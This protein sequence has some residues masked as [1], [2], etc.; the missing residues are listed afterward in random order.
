MRKI[1][2]WFQALCTR[3]DHYLL[4]MSHNHL[5]RYRKRGA[6]TQEEI[7]FLLGAACGTK[8]S[9]HERASRPPS[10][11]TALAYQ[12]IFGVPVH[13]LF[14]EDYREAVT[15]VKGRATRLAQDVAHRP[16]SQKTPF[17]ERVLASAVSD[18]PVSPSH[19]YEG[20]TN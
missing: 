18:T 13:E 6:L 9:R 4:S 14:P 20:Q 7:A 17:K 16:D 8:V 12:V 11:Q 1:A 19:K 15:A 5:R 3:H 2:S 10:L